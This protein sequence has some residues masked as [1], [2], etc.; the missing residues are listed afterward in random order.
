MS[1]LPGVWV[2]LFVL[3]LLLKAKYKQ[4]K[5]VD[6]NRL[7]CCDLVFIKVQTPTLVLL[8]GC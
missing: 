7:Q 8:A 2:Q 6:F 5:E 3:L 4:R 1:S